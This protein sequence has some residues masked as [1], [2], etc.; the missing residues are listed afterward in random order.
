MT[1]GKSCTCPNRNLDIYRACH[2]R[3]LVRNSRCS[4]FEGYQQM[5][6]PYSLVECRRCGLVWRTKAK[7]VGDLPD[8]EGNA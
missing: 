7:Y 3:V 4:A 6:S 5:W 2:W 8:E 1:Q